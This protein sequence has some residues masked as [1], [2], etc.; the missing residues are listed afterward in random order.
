M[1]IIL[2]K[3]VNI[4]LLIIIFVGLSVHGLSQSYVSDTVPSDA[5]SMNNHRKILPPQKLSYG[6]TLGTQF[7]GSRYASA[8]STIVSPH[9][10]YRLNDRF[11]LSGGVS[12]I[13]T[14][15]NGQ[16]YNP[17]ST[18]ESTI[19][20]N[21][22]SALVYLS[23]NYLVNNRVTVSGTA[24]KQ[25]NFLGDV[26]GSKG[27]LNNDLQGFYMNVKYKIMENVNFEAGFGYSSGVN[28]YNPFNRCHD[29]FNR[30]F[31]DP[32]FGPTH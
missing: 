11:S 23:G 31:D 20:G 32:F 7:S 2:G 17:F 19:S 29:P 18:T 3:K 1:K 14:T 28:P 12:V 4:F 24:Y 9:L 5:F 8:F 16:F 25:F 10:S 21:Y 26:P 13:N 30:S 22:T 27:F 6:V 15:V